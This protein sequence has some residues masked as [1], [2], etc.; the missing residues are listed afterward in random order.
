[1]AQRRPGDG[2]SAWRQ[3]AHATTYGG[4]RLGLEQ[5]PARRSAGMRE[6]GQRCTLL[7]GG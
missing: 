7:L 4:L 2:R 3:A 5:R 6:R 1:M